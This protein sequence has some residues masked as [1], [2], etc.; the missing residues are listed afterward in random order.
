[1][2]T[3]LLVCA[4]MAAARL[5]E[6][7]LSRRNL[8]ESGPTVESDLSRATY[9]LIVGVHM[10]A[11][12]GTLLSGHRRSTPWLLLLLAVQP[13]RAWVLWTLGRRW[14]ARGAVSDETEVEMGGPY[15]LVRHPNYAIGSANSSTI[16]MA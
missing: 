11:I 4:S 6:L 10:L 16:T 13:L 14:N 7:A 3:R 5:G 9:P 1:M 15:A 12:A 2:L 8:S